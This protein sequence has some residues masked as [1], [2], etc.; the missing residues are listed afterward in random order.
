[1]VGSNRKEKQSGGQSPSVRNAKSRPFTPRKQ[2]KFCN[3]VSHP[4]H[5]CGIRKE[6]CSNEVTQ[7][8]IVTDEIHNEVVIRLSDL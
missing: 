3:D 8:K 6:F 2:K 7:I 4:I 5:S 1:M